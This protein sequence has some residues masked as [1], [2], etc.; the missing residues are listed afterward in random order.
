MSHVFQDDETLAAPL[1]GPRA[2]V[3]GWPVWHSRSPLIHGTWLRELRLAGSYQRLGIPPE[4]IGEFLEGFLAG[5]FV[6]GNVTIPHKEAV[7]RALDRRDA[8]AEAIGAVNTLWREGGTL[9]GGNT[10][11]YGFSANLDERLSGWA[12]ATEALVL[13][14][15]GAARAVVHAL[16][17]RGV[18]RVAILNRTS[19]RAIA[20]AESFGARASGHGEEE[21]ETLLARTDLL[22][23]TVPIPPV[24]PE[25]ARFGYEPPLPDL[26]ALPDHALVTDI[27]YVPIE[28]PVLRAARARDLRAADG[29]GMLLHQAAPG[30]ERW[31]G[32]R[33]EVTPALRDAV[34]A[35]I[36]RAG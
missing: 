16:L 33:P 20:L 17:E 34:L 15:G 8:A 19:D 25:M 14:A 27:V 32:R 30:F 7:F 3:T 9:V 22:V 10:D 24:D 28:T 29:L 31:F 2:F 1:D 5:P 4:E 36:A 23:N 35:D 11:A 13:G 26:S 12:D 18:T 21:R 6:G